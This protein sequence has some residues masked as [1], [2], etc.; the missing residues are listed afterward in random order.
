M[1]KVIDFFVLSAI[2]SGIR[3]RTLWIWNHFPTKLLQVIDHLPF[4]DKIRVGGVSTHLHRLAKLAIGKLRSLVLDYSMASYMIWHP[5]GE[6]VESRAP[7]LELIDIGENCTAAILH[8]LA[9]GVFPKLAHLNIDFGGFCHADVT[10]LRRLCS[11]AAASQS[12]HSEPDSSTK[13]GF[14]SSARRRIRAYGEGR[15]FGAVLLIP[16]L[17]LLSSWIR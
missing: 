17:A 8:C 6:L 13:P 16:Q 9:E 5:F 14:R 15:I 4:W 3:D 2:L 11:P 7:Y 1:C 12:K 10:V